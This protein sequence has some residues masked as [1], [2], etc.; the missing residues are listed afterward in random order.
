MVVAVGP[1]RLLIAFD[2]CFACLAVLPEP[3]PMKTIL[4]FPDLEALRFPGSGSA[5]AALTHSCASLIWKLAG[6]PCHVPALGAFAAVTHVRPFGSAR[7]SQ[8]PFQPCLA[9]AAL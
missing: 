4:R 3:W 7:G 8:H 1:Q 2:A 6:A 9:A 5:T